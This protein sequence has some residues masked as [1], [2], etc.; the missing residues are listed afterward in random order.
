MSWLSEYLFKGPK[1]AAD[2]RRGLRRCAHA[3]GGGTDHSAQRLHKRIGFD[4][5]H[6]AANQHGSNETNGSSN[7]ALSSGGS[8]VAHHRFTW[9]QIRP[10]RRVAEQPSAKIR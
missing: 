1:D 9:A 5:Q 10:G 3:M 8:G 6:P 4:R 2:V 7:Q